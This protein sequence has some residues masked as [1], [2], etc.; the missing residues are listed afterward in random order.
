MTFVKTIQVY[1]G[2]LTK[3]GICSILKP[4]GYNA[5]SLLCKQVAALN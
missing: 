2:H 1:A 4:L 5:G 3:M